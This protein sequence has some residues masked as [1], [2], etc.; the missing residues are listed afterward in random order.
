MS[1]LY[2]EALACLLAQ[3]LEKKELETYIRR[4]KPSPCPSSPEKT[5]EG[6]GAYQ[7]SSRSSTEEEA[8]KEGAF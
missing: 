7:S 6:S 3:K 1:L 4:S 5:H 2:R 8:E